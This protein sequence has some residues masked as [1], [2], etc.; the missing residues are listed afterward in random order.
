MSLLK[1]AATLI[2]SDSIYKI[3]EDLTDTLVQNHEFKETTTNT[4]VRKLKYDG[5]SYSI[6]ISKLHLVVIID[7]PSGRESLLLDTPYR[8][9]EFIS[10]LHELGVKV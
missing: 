2:H 1:R 8:L 5:R 9:Y 4:Y 3:L 7:K 6:R 10:K